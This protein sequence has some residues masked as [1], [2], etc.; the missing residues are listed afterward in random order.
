MAKNEFLPFGTAANT[1]VLPNADYQALPARAVL[2]V[3][4]LPTNRPDNN[5]MIGA[6]VDN[7]NYQL[8]GFD[9]VS[10]GIDLTNSS[11]RKRAYGFTWFAF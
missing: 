11:T 1:K 9:V 7:T 10:Y 6:N 3:S 5:T 8:T 4:V 2:S